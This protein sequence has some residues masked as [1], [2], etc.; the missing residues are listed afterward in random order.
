MLP[1]ADS[2]PPGLEHDRASVLEFD[3]DVDMDDDD[4]L[5]VDLDDIEI[6][7]WTGDSLDELGALM[8]RTEDFF[9][10]GEMDFGVDEKARSIL[11][12]EGRKPQVAATGP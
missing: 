12:T 6:V 9:G 2:P 11:I 3:R 1:A 8:S 4:D 10:L 5:D 7:A